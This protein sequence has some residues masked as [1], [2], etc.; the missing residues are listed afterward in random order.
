MGNNPDKETLP[1]IQLTNIYDV[2][3]SVLKSYKCALADA[4]PLRYY[5]K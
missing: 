3:L 5:H 1:R 2:D 4:L